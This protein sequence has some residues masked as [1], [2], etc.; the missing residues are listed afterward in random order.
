MR[1][2]GGMGLMGLV[3]LLALAGC[4]GGFGSPPRLVH[5][6]SG[7]FTNAFLQGTYAFSLSGTNSAG[8]FSTA[9]SLQADGNGNITSGVQDVNAASGV[10]TDLAITGTYS[11]AADGRGTATLT[12]SATSMTLDFVLISAQH[13]LVIRFQGA[14]TASGTIDLQTPAAFSLAALQGSF[15]FNLSGV[16]ARGGS[17]ASAGVFTTNGAGGITGGVEDLNDS[18]VA[19]TSLP[20]T[21]SYTVAANGRGTAT[22]VTT[23]GTFNFAFHVV[24][25][26]HLKLVETDL[27]PAQGGD[28]FR[29]QG[30]ISNASFSGPHAFTR[31]GGL[32]SPFVAG[33]VITADGSGSITSGVED[34]NDNGFVTK[35][36]SLT[37]TYAIAANGRGTLALVGSNGTANFAI[38]PSSGGLQMVQLDSTN[39]TTGTAYPQQAGTFSNASLNGPYGYNLTAAGAVGPTDAVAQFTAD[40]NGTATG[41]MDFNNSGFLEPRLAVNATYS[42]ESNGRGIMTLRTS[43]ATQALAVYLISNSRALVIELNFDSVGIGSFEHQ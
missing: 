18:G 32:F 28:A 17:F 3:L 36:L 2:A 39:V 27:A 41:A 11:V 22:L 12:S 23:A 26:D 7:P 21:G 15:A 31:A 25:G 10:F 4:G 5:T 20:L 40:G 37:G 30:A 42:M 33:G 43:A 14:A 35:N 13:G 24:D 6:V 29:Q 9:G 38:Y 16:D 19:Q 1:K 34:I 8:F